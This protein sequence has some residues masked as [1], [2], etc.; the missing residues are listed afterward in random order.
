MSLHTISLVD[1]SND[2]TADQF[3]AIIQ[4][5]IGAK[6]IAF[7]ASVPALIVSCSDNDL[8]AVVELLQ[9]SGYCV[10]ALPRVRFYTI[11]YPLQILLISIT[12][13]L[14]LIYLN[15]AQAAA[16]P[17]PVI[18][19]PV[20]D[21]G[22]FIT[23]RFF[24]IIFIMLINIQY[25][26][27]S[28][29]GP[30]GLLS[31]D[32][33][34]CTGIIIVFLLGLYETIPVFMGINPSAGNF[35][36]ETSCLIIVLA[37]ALKVCETSHIERLTDSLRQDADF[38]ASA[39]VLDLDTDEEKQ[40]SS[41]HLQ[42]DDIV[43]IKTGQTI[44]ADGEIS[45]G[46]GSVDES[47]LTGS[48]D[49]I[50]KAPG[51]KVFL[52]T[53]NTKGTFHY[54]VSAA[55]NE[56]VL[57][58][59]TKLQKT[60]ANMNTDIEHTT[61]KIVR[62]SAVFTIFSS[63]FAAALAIYIKESPA[64]IFS[65]LASILVAGYPPSVISSA[66]IPFLSAA[67]QWYTCGIFFKNIRIIEQIYHIDT[68]ILG[69]TGILT[70]GMPAVAALQ[71]EGITPKVLL[72]L[73]ASTEKDLKHTLSKALLA[74]SVKNQ[75]H[76]QRISSSQLIEG[77]GA[78][79]LVNGDIVRVGKASWLKEE[80]IN[81]SN[82][83]QMKGFQISKEGS[84]PIY[85][86]LRKYCHGVLTMTDSIKY[87]SKTALAHLHNMKINTMLFTGDNKNTAKYIADQLSITQYKAELLPDD[88]AQEIELLH[89]HGL[90]VAAVGNADN[91]LPMLR[92]ADIGI[93]LDHNVN[94]AAVSAA[95]II[96]PGGSL[97]RVA[98]TIKFCR[99]M[100]KHIH[101]KLICV[102]V[103][104][105][106][107]LASIFIFPYY[108][109]SAEFFPAAAATAMTLLGFLVIKIPLFLHKL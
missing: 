55:V 71:A 91:D 13:L 50:D 20:H 12:A 19:D 100:M 101:C 39:A 1:I 96:Y 26:F 58:Q 80:G 60:A 7:D 43:T 42:P 76:L 84:T 78:E 85:I 27:G 18:I 30:A 6:I 97:Q 23:A 105:F 68:V 41:S 67:R 29:K 70:E 54:R 61:I 37:T 65:V 57:L 45:W 64:F 106:L 92:A 31:P 52:G 83:L 44:P 74:S 17:L 98:E 11:K 72:S 33:L 10:G 107:V 35:Y 87:G 88:K 66:R 51:D 69:K 46:E 94:P 36:G 34:I 49:L 63:L 14:F 5:V 73:A 93:F 4:S 59:L 82:E 16:L 15:L 103:F 24:I 47:K 32:L 53:I 21:Q 99:Y 75:A 95:D 2:A 48:F 22:A 86:A 81:I 38:P 109:G 108:L 77:S 40:V 79:A 90:T 25:F 8:A 9:N 102:A 56:S 62:A 3:T 104:F 28:T 89:T